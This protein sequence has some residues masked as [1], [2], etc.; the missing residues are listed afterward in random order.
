MI[1]LINQ[2]S[3]TLY[4]IGKTKNIKQ[5]IKQLQVGCPLTILL[6]FQFDVNSLIESKLEKTIHRRFAYCK[7]QGEW[8]DFRDISEEDIKNNILKI[9][10][11]I[12]YLFEEQ[13]LVE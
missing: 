7:T 8:F 12:K 9:H 2:E 13:K 3:T 11:T 5:R 6:V 4:K 10:E 1:Y